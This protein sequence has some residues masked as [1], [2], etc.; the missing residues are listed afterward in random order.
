L[1]RFLWSTSK[2]TNLLDY[3]VGFNK[4]NYGLNTAK[5]KYEWQITNFEM[6]T[7]GIYGIANLLGHRAISFNALLA[8]RAKGTFSSR[9]K[10]AVN[11][12]IELV[13]ERIIESAQ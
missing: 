3:F 1:S 11:Q 5:K 7:A 4:K 8:N 12:L 2:E 13:L 6:E 10:Q 9:P